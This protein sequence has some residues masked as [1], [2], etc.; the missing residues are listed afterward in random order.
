MQSQS[1]VQTAT[2]ANFRELVLEGETPVI[3]DFWRH[4]V[5]GARSSHPFMMSFL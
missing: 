5:S 2:S 3:V 1:N 4:G